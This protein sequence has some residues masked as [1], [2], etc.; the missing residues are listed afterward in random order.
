MKTLLA[1]IILTL[2]INA[3]ANQGQTF[4]ERW[5]IDGRTKLAKSLRTLIEDTTGVY[6]RLITERCQADF[7]G[8]ELDPYARGKFKIK[9]DFTKE[10]ELEKDFED[11]I[12]SVVENDAVSIKWTGVFDEDDDSAPLQLFFESN[13]LMLEFVKA[14]EDYQRSCL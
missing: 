7:S 14:I 9:F 8:A 10:L 1:L 12:L 4:W 13:E 11:S 5:E 6:P 2:S 3:S